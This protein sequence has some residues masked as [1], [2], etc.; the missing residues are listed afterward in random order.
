MKI[1]I[2]PPYQNK[3]GFTQPQTVELMEKLEKIN[4]IAREEYIIDEGY[5]IDWI[6]ERRDAEFLA[7][8]DVGIIRKVKEYNEQGGIDAIVSLG[9][10]EPAFYAARQISDVPYLSALHSALHVASLLGEKCS[11]IEATD[12]QAILVRRHAKMYGFDHKLMSARYVGFSSTFMGRSL[13][14]CPKAHRANDPELKT[15]ILK[16]VNQCIASVEEDGA[17]S[18]ILSCMPLQ[19]LEEEVREQFDAAGFR[20]IPL[21]CELSASVAMA[22]AVVGMNLTHSLIANPRDD[23]KLK[24]DTR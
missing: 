14:S 1:V 17:D 23:N 10:M 20:D 8:I 4:L 3:N 15:I 2:M 11:V 22:K 12:P 19:V 5:F 24:P 13:A 18:V 21:I 16:I 6:E 9:S 7:N